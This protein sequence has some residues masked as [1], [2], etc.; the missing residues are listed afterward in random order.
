MIL[1]DTFWRQRLGA[2]KEV[3]GTAIRLDGADYTV[4]GILPPQVG[5]FE[6]AQNFFLVAKMPPPPRRGP[7]PYTV[8]GRLRQGVDPRS[9]IGELQTINRRIFPLWKSSYQDD[10]ATWNMADLKTRVVGDVDAIAGL[11]L[12]AVALVWLIACVNASNLLVAR[13]TSRRRELIVRAAL[14]ASRGRVLRPLFVESA[15][16]AAGAA[17]LGI[18]LARVG[19]SVLR[20]AGADY[21][22][23]TA[24]WC[25]V[26]ACSFSSRA[27]GHQ[28]GIFAIVPALQGP[29]FG[30]TNRC[31][32]AV[33]APPA[34]LPGVSA[35]RSSPGSSRSAH[36]CSSSPRSCWSA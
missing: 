27:D 9:A 4:A 5:P 34:S 14:G 16:L 28:R 36:R 30:S 13:V 31:A 7:F 18:V 23:R 21:L 1:S 2:R 19:V 29:I 15:L 33:R 32:A 25:L 11:S 17:A 12:V 26:A 6:Q 22:P 24:E 35:R 8:I 20:S 3:A 10:K